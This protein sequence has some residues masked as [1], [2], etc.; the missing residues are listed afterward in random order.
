MRAETEIMST[1]ENSVSTTSFKQHIDFFSSKSGQKILTSLQRGIEKEGLRAN[2]DATLAMTPH[3]ENL[4]SALTNPWLTTDFSESLFEFI[5]PVFKSIDEC[6]NYLRNIHSLAYKKLDEELIWATS[7]PCILPEDEQIPIAQYGSSNI[8]K[9]K[10]IYR[11]G[12]GNRYGRSMQTVAGI[13]YNFS[14]PDEY[15]QRAFAD[16]KTN[17]ETSTSDLQTY[18]NERYLDLIRNFRRNYWILIYLFGAAPCADKSFV[19]GREHN[20]EQLGEDDLYLPQSTSLRM[21][22]LGYQSKAQ[23]SLF[24]CYN[25]LDTYIRTLGEA[26]HQPY[27]EYEDIG[28][29]ED[30]EYKQLSTALLQIENE[31]YSPI[32]PKRVTR[33]GETPLRALVERGIEYIEVRCLDINPFVDVG[34]DEQ[35]MRF[36]DT[37]LLYCL[38]KES[39]QCDEQEFQ[40]ISENQ[41]RVVNAGR[42]PD[43]QIYCGKKEIPMREC[44]SHMLNDITKVA[45][46]LDLAHASEDYSYS[47]ELQRLKLEDASL[48]PSAKCL[49][50]MAVNHESHIEFSR[51]Q[52][53]L[54]AK[55]FI[56]AGIPADVEQQLISEVEESLLKKQELE[57]DSSLSFEDFLAAYYKQ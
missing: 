1:G 25:E 38:T 51:R 43:L 31:F 21:G 2:K 33:S 14:M 15:W 47:L 11:V 53:E 6:L 4:G 57:K 45:E 27:K 29:L 56:K 37:F 50:T 22:D 16:A 20:M 32:R 54:F 24:V 26:I 18:I 36:L 49:H 35:T 39:T 3:P 7:M 10:T 9:M 12:L 28:L 23:Q 48:T 52:T 42:D 40:H 8:A 19:R 44:A 46:Q 34:I 5:T 13:H 17:N 30:G 55:E 41:A